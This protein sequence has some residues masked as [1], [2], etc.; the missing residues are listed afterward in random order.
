MVPS[1]Y[2]ANSS[3]AG[4]FQQGAYLYLA[5]VSLFFPGIHSGKFFSC[6]RFV[7]VIVA[8]L[9]ALD[10]LDKPFVWILDSGFLR[11]RLGE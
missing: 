1:P 6:R 4:I 10:Q 8:V 2:V 5:F 7:R 9:T 3:V 11:G